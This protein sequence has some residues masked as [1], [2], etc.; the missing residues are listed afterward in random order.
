MPS[1]EPQ[2]IRQE[3]IASLVNKGPI[4]VTD[5]QIAPVISQ[6]PAPMIPQDPV[7]VMPSQGVVGSPDFIIPDKYKLVTSHEN[8]LNKPML[9]QGTNTMTPSG[10]VQGLPW[11][12]GVVSQV[13]ECVPACVSACSIQCTQQNLVRSQAIESPV[14]STLAATNVPMPGSGISTPQQPTNECVAACTRL[15]NAECTHDRPQPR[16]FA[17]EHV[18]AQLSPTPVPDQFGSL[19]PL[20]PSTTECLPSISETECACPSGFS[21]C[22]TAKCTHDRQKPR[23]F[24]SEPIPAQLSPTPVPDQ[25]ASLMSLQPSTTECLPPMSE[26]ECACPGGFTV[27]VAASGSNQ[28][29]RIR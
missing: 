2:C 8:E 6:R 20:Q 3:Q 10:G 24:A 25:F 23:P 26:T 13:Q 14:Y 7:T 11:F 28:C 15:C 29:C 1:C 5:E 16:T 4:S 22:V 19:V 21:V 27:C 12:S 18:P 9:P 17:P